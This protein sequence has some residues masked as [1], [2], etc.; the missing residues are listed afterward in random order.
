[1]ENKEVNRNESKSIGQKN[2]RKVQDYQ[3]KR[4]SKGNL[5]EPETQAE[6]GIRP[7]F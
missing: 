2:M 3:E 5:R 7:I 4:E 6:A 1:M